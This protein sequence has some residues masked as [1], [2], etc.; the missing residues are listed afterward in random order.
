MNPTKKPA[1]VQDDECTIKKSVEQTIKN[2]NESDQDIILIPSSDEDEKPCIDK[3]KLKA[4]SLP[5]QIELKLPTHPASSLIQSSSLWK[6]NRELPLD[7]SVPCD[8]ESDDGLIPI[9]RLVR[10]SD[11]PKPD[12]EFINE[13]ISEPVH[14]CFGV[15]SNLA[16]NNDDDDAISEHSGHSEPIPMIT[17]FLPIRNCEMKLITDEHCDSKKENQMKNSLE[18]KTSE[19]ASVSQDFPVKETEILP[20]T[21]ETIPVS[22]DQDFPVKET[23]ILPFTVIKETEP[24]S[25]NEISPLPIEKE[26]AQRD[27]S[28]SPSNSD[29]ENIFD[30]SDNDFQAY[31]MKSKWCICDRDN[32][33]TADSKI[34]EGCTQWYHLKCLNYD[35]KTIENIIKKRG[36]ED[37]IC[38]VCKE[39]KEFIKKYK[40]KIDYRTQHYSRYL[41]S[42]SCRSDT[43]ISENESIKFVPPRKIDDDDEFR[44]VTNFHEI[45]KKLSPKRPA[46]VGF[47]KIQ[48]ENSK[49]NFLTSKSS[50]KID[51][52][53]LKK[54][55]EPKQPLKTSS[56]SINKIPSVKSVPYT[57]D[58]TGQPIE[59]R[60][61][62]KCIY[63]RFSLKEKNHPAPKKIRNDSKFNNGNKNISDA[64]FDSV[65]C[66]E[67]CIHNYLDE[68]LSKHE[69][70]TAKQID[71]LDSITKRRQKSFF[72][73]NY[74]T[75]E[76]IRKKMYEFLAINPKYFIMSRK[77]K[78]SY[79]SKERIPLKP[80]T[81]TNPK[82]STSKI[83]PQ[84]KH[85]VSDKHSIEKPIKPVV[86]TQQVIK[87]IM[88]DPSSYMTPERE[89]VIRQ[90]VMQL[91]G[92]YNLTPNKDD[93]KIDEN[94]I[95][96]LVEKIEMS[97]HN[98]FFDPK[99]YI[100][101]MRAIIM[102]LTNK[103]NQ[104]FYLKILD[105]RFTPED[106]PKITTEQM[107]DDKLNDERSKQRAEDLRNTKKYSDEVNME[108]IKPS[109][110]KTSKGEEYVGDQALSMPSHFDSN[111]YF[112]S[113]LDTDESSQSSLNSEFKIKSKPKEISS[114]L[115]QPKPIATPLIKHSSH[116]QASMPF[117]GT[118]LT[119]PIALNVL[120]NDTTSQHCLGKHIMDVNCKICLGQPNSLSTTPE[121]P[122]IIIPKETTEQSHLTFS[123]TETERINFLKE[124]NEYFIRNKSLNNSLNELDPLPNFTTSFNEPQFSPEQLATSENSDNLNSKHF[125][126]GE[127]VANGKNLISL[128]AEMVENS[129]ESLEV[130]EKITKASFPDRL[131]LGTQFPLNSKRMTFWAY[132][133]HLKENLNAKLVFFNFNSNEGKK[134]KLYVPSRDPIIM[135]DNDMFS[136]FFNHLIESEKMFEYK[137]PTYLQDTIG[138]IYLAPLKNKNQLECPRLKTKFGISMPRNKD[139][140]IG[141]IIDY[142]T[143]KK[144]RLPADFSLYSPLESNRSEG[145][146]TKRKSNELDNERSTSEIPYEKKKPKYLDY[147]L[148]RKSTDDN[149]EDIKRSKPISPDEK[150]VHF[151]NS[152]Q[153]NLPGDDILF[154][155]AQSLN[156]VTK[157]SSKDSCEAGSRDP[158]LKYKISKKS[159]EKST[160]ESKPVETLTLK[161][162]KQKQE[163]D[164]SK[165]ETESLDSQILKFSQRL[166]SNEMSK[167]EANICVQKFITTN[168]LSIIQ[169]ATIL[170]A[171]TEF[172]SEMNVP[173]TE[174]TNQVTTPPDADPVI[175]QAIEKP[176]RKKP[177][178]FSEPLPINTKFHKISNITKS[179]SDN[180]IN[181]KNI[182]IVLDCD[183]SDTYLAI[184]RLL[185]SH[186]LSDYHSN[187]SESL[188]LSVGLKKNLN[189]ILE[190]DAKLI[191]KLN[192]KEIQLLKAD[193]A[194]I[195][196]ELLN[197]LNA[198]SD[199]VI[200][201]DENENEIVSS[202][203]DESHEKFTSTGWVLH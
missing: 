139:Q 14:N 194:K 2:E 110:K 108:K 148:K 182:E 119:L 88:A 157:T 89:K 78:E 116:S 17:N 169:K 100:N 184:D 181:K 37:F 163:A 42:S 161:N 189:E 201:L 200:T 77:Y 43:E 118:K 92:R 167:E 87:P 111:D 142:E 4:N 57:A 1:S 154:T 24:A 70:K 22:F 141:V 20:I 128:N 99:K 82:P 9:K 97:C 103:S 175:V 36:L 152:F 113:T 13:E 160:S 132:L 84:T 23:K 109:I 130:V 147:T 67:K 171:L 55:G 191:R 183:R 202:R 52:K 7:S 76:H 186:S 172:L 115:T 41:T 28:P 180:I 195:Y 46:A 94:D 69:H 5:E 12:G 34:C 45:S 90:L 73:E 124:Q 203:A 159:S 74:K 156:E 61:G 29:K 134:S 18:T 121:I 16:T 64:W 30:D 3:I 32:L 187:K 176:K 168:E 25:I 47:K 54:L 126:K 125:W 15:M 65:Y 19:I 144:F 165:P 58:S 174:Q 39:D 135:D 106:L 49:K 27:N 91:K 199:E 127:L 153:K 198:K 68:N 6:L 136:I 188:F 146:L 10:R 107:G 8:T 71:L 44:P 40:T 192:R 98:H 60:R 158:R 83:L 101:R 112:R 173:S 162:D 185:S 178:R 38:P 104:T 21:K 131:E 72:T 164:N 35:T 81:I 122:D 123:S 62:L 50:I 155:P 170:N 117:I 129:R 114:S 66:D 190:V 80:V 86:M 79:S 51:S 59:I 145:H 48:Q 33:T 193:Y 105:G 53:D 85:S 133:E 93:L 179:A 197:M 26:T 166:K 137:V 140:L 75:F 138:Y 56:D 63:C 31:E 149:E 143:K 11:L 177:S 102:N 196:P 96:K 120:N 150:R 95:E 151:A